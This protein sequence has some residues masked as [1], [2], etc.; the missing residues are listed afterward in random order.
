MPLKNLYND[1]PRLGN[2]TTDQDS[3]DRVLKRMVNTPPLNIGKD[4]G[5]KVMHDGVCEECKKEKISLAKGMCQP[6]YDRKRN[7]AKPKKRIAPATKPIPENMIPVV[8]QTSGAVIVDL[9]LIPGLGDVLTEKARRELRTVEMQ[10]L[11][12]LSWVMKEGVA[13]D[14]MG[15]KE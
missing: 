8:K 5:D 7:A 2:M 6:C 11:W 12:E 1:D 13:K 15:A 10:C 3:F 4:R 14:V 9:S